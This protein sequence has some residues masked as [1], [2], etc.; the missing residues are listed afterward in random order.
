[1]HPGKLRQC[2]LVPF[3]ASVSFLIL[4]RLRWRHVQVD[5]EGADVR[6]LQQCFQVLEQL[7]AVERRGPVIAVFETI[8]VDFDH[9]HVL[10]SIG[11]RRRLGLEDLRHAR[12]QRGCRQFQRQVVVVQYVH[13]A[14]DY[15]GHIER[16]RQ[17][18]PPPVNEFEEDFPNHS[19]SF[20]VQ[21][22]FI[23][24]LTR[25]GTFSGFLPHSYRLLITRPAGSA[26]HVAGVACADLA[27]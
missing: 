25:S 15:G 19:S 13:T 10:S 23:V 11:R 1:M 4:P 2:R 12:Q 20:Q 27:P 22:G 21:G 24:L 3:Q 18:V 14:G 6:V 16:A 26:L 8:A 7:A 5:R 9:C 17:M